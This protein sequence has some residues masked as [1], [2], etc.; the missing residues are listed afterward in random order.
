M[1][2]TITMLQT[3]TPPVVTFAVSRRSACALAFA[4]AVWIA[5]PAGI[6]QAAG[7]DDFTK[8]TAGS[9]MAV[10]HTT[11]DRLL[12]AYVKPDAT[13]LNRVDY[14][15][16]KAEGHKDLKGYVAMLQATDVAKLDKPEQFAFWSNLYNAVTVD[17]V[18]DKYPV[19]SIKDIA[20]GGGFK[21]LVGGGPW[22]A[23]TAK[24]AGVAIS[25]D[26]IEH[27]ILRPVFK[28]ARVHYALNCASYGC[29]NLQ[30][31]AFTGKDLNAQLDAG[32]KSFVNHPRGITVEGGKVKA[33][34][35]YSWFE[36]DFGGSAVKA[37][38]HIRSYAEPALK[39]KLD[40]VTKIDSY[41]YVWTLNDIAN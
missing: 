28:D 25:L 40:G 31:G 13:G 14:K 34:N 38:E 33:S 11:W 24:V 20:L 29:P 21:A 18:L 10:D 37:L 22:Q 17:V 9:T 23:S 27:K 39:Q 36:A 16:F 2:Q 8:H 32:A 3:S 41:D 15:K 6:A 35:I 12:K 1:L 7:L 5:V 26:D 30:V 19:K 4:A